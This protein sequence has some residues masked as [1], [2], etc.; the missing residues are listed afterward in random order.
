MTDQHIIERYLEEILAGKDIFLVGVK[1]DKDNRIVVHVDTPDGIHIDECVEVSRELED[2]L[3]R[4]K[5]DFALEVSSPGLDS[6][7][8]VMEQYRKNIGREISVVKTDGERLEGT[9]KAAGDQGIV[10]KV[11]SQKKGQSPSTALHELSFAKIKTARAII[12]F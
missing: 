4:D 12:K 9:L 10:L 2:K 3:E 7:F 11:A 6:P 8:R 5:E 1:V